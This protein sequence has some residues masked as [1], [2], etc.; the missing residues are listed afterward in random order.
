MY[1]CKKLN[2]S[3]EVIMLVTYDT[4]PNIQNEL[5]SEITEEEYNEFQAE[6]EAQQENTEQ[7]TEDY[8]QEQDFLDALALL[9]V[10]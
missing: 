9:G 3:G 1:Y 5:I 8:A 7:E 2:D 4:K 6:F 10:E